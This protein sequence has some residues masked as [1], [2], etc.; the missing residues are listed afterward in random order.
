[1]DAAPHGHADSPRQ[2]PPPNPSPDPP[3]LGARTLNVTL[4]SASLS[5][6]KGQKLPLIRGLRSNRDAEPRRWS[7]AGADARAGA[8]PAALVLQL[9]Y[10]ASRRR[11][12]RTPSPGTVS[13]P[14]SPRHLLQSQHQPARVTDNGGLTPAAVT[15]RDFRP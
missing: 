2:S 12:G 8:S 5:H 14:P 1:M 10:S 11:R 4:D 15:T 7:A 9:S 13:P 3:L 6:P